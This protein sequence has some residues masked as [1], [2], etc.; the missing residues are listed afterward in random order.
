MFREEH[1]PW[2]RV[3][4]IRAGI[5]ELESKGFQFGTL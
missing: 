5:D 2:W 1:D 4:D 3:D